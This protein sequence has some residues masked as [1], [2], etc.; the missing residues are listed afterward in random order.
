MNPGQPSV[1]TQLTIALATAVFTVEARYTDE[2]W[3]PIAA[4]RYFDQAH[5]FVGAMQRRSDGWDFRIVELDEVP[6]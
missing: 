5:L 3:E 4:F 1:R 6:G 2:P